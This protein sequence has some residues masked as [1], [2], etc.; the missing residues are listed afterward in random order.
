MPPKT[1]GKKQSGTKTKKTAEKLTPNELLLDYKIGLARSNLMELEF[2]RTKLLE[3]IENKESELRELSKRSEMEMK[4]TMDKW[5]EFK[6]SAKDEITS[7]QVIDCMHSNW[8][9]K[10]EEQK[11]IHS[12]QEQIRQVRANIEET[13]REVE[14]WKYFEAK[15]M[16]SNAEFIVILRQEIDS[17]KDRYDSFVENIKQAFAEKKSDYFDTFR[18]K[19]E[20]IRKA[21]VDAAVGKLDNQHW[22]Q[23]EQEE[24]FRKELFILKQREQELSKRIEEIENMNIMI[25]DRLAQSRLNPM[26]WP[27]RVPQNFPQ[28]T[29]N[30]YYSHVLDLDVSGYFKNLQ[31]SSHQ[32][33]VDEVNLGNVKTQISTEQEGPTM[34]LQMCEYQQSVK[35]SFLS[36]NMSALLSDLTDS[37]RWNRMMAVGNEEVQLLNIRGVSPRPNSS[38][39][40]T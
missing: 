38:A 6:K 7:A 26:L 39:T 31:L 13:R 2:K 28:K 37:D 30:L 34:E 18:S 5:K 22:T 33:L 11:A 35:D 32:S 9:V 17:M 21:S 40:E 24:W 3:Q 19:L 20:T 8:K 1:K 36:E 27:A 15:T 16:P 14:R 10:D 29:D 12:I 25:C 23:L 4:E